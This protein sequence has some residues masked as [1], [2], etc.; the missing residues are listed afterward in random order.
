[1]F[2]LPNSRLSDVRHVVSTDPWRVDDGTS[3]AKSVG[4]MSEIAVPPT[5]NEPT[6]MWRMQRRDGCRAH[7]LID[8]AKG[9]TRVVW[10]VNSRPVGARYV[11]DWTAAIQWTERLQGQYWIFGWRLC[12]DVTEDRPGRSKTG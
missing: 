11:E 10:F 8:T 12:D 1:V 5:Y 2:S 3:L 4:A 9:R 6:V 7:A